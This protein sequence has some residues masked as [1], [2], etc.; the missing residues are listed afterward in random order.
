MTWIRWDTGTPRSEVVTFL[1]DRLG[2]KPVT[3][4]GHYVALCCAL[5]EERRDGRIDQVTDTALEHWALWAGK[6]G[7]FAA[8][9]RAWCEAPKAANPDHD[10]GEL[11]GWW[12]QRALLEKQE[13]DARKPDGRKKAGT[14]P[15]KSR[16]NPPGDSGG[17]LGG[18]DNDNGNGYEDEDVTSPQKKLPAAAAAALV[19]PAIA[20]AVAAN[21]GLKAN[22]KLRT[23]KELLPQS[24]E[25]AVKQW[26][27]EGIPLDV[28]T[29]AVEHRCATYPPKRPG[30]QPRTFEY[31]DPVVRAALDEARGR[32]ALEQGQGTA[33]TPLL[34]QL[35]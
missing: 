10:A 5:G 24:A 25:A 8:A 3:A 14:L 16:A 13:A 28:I 34:P 4:L 2:V 1:A 20:V 7:R 22:P 19:A 29:A 23:P 27:G 30:D 31:F 35:T 11:R 18:N 17:S 9:I 32:A 15:P 6:P 12:R 26:L 33:A 21:R